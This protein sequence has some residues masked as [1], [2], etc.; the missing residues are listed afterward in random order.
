MAVMNHISNRMNFS[1]Y[2]NHSRGQE[3]LYNTME[4]MDILDVIDTEKC[5][6]LGIIRVESAQIRVKVLRKCNFGASK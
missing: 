4:V 1:C 2:T 5:R 6:K 3:G